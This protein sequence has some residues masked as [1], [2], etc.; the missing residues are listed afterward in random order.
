MDLNGTE[1][2]QDGAAGYKVVI[3]VVPSLLKSNPPTSKVEGR[4]EIGAL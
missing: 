1:I 3:H 4:D 2:Q